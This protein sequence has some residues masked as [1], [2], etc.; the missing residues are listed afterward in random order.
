MTQRPA[1]AEH[2]RIY[3]YLRAVY[4]VCVLVACC[5]H[6]ILT[7]PRG[8]RRRV[9]WRQRWS[10]IVLRVFR[11]R[12][13]VHGQVPRSGVLAGNHLGYLDILTYGCLM[14]AVF[15]GKR[16]LQTW[17]LIGFITRAGGTIYIDR[18]NPR[19]AA[20]ANRAVAEALR[21]G[22]PVVFFPEG[23]SSDGSTILPVHSPLFQAAVEQ[24]APVWTAAIAYTAN[25]SLEGTGDSI[26]YWGDMSFGPHLLRLLRLRKIAAHLQIASEPIHAGDRRSAAGAAEIVMRRLLADARRAATP[27]AGDAESAPSERRPRQTATA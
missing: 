16:E 5:A 3:G 10:R 15:V 1:G 25:G 18:Q 17:P 9:E 13:D 7:R 26:C 8:L 21:E 27:H 11:I 6:F 2:S 14:P 24:H 23:T 19:S 20:E 22:L 12:L 4:V